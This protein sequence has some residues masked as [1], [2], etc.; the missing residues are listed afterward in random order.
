M[1]TKNHT[2]ENVTAAEEARPVVAPRCDVHESDKAFHV[3]AEMPGVA[4]EAVEVTLE[5]NV[6]TIRGRTQSEM[7]QGYRLL[8]REFEP[9]DYRR[10]FELQSEVDPS[11]V[12]ASMNAGVLRVEVQKRVTV[13]RRIPVQAG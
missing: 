12:R 13:E 5:R 8:W 11:A 3:T 7:P 2:N 10:A 9:V 4:P 1:N 6:L